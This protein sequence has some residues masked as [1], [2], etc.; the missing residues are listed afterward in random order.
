MAANFPQRRMRG[1]AL[2][3]LRRAT[4]SLLVFATTFCGLS[5]LAEAYRHYHRSGPS[6][7]QIKMMQAYQK[8]MQQQYE[9]MQKQQAAEQQAF[10]SKFDTNNDGVISGK[11]KGPAKKYLRELEL[12]KAGPLAAPVTLDAPGNSKKKKK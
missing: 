5:Q 4:L 10:M 6:P 12:G 8:Q 3:L 9:L 1:I 11:E 7:Q 2:Q